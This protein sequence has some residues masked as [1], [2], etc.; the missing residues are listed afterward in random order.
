MKETKAENIKVPHITAYVYEDGKGNKDAII[1]HKE[2]DSLR[3]FSMPESA[4]A[5]DLGNA[6]NN[7][8]A[9]IEWDDDF[10]GLFLRQDVRKAF[11]EVMKDIFGDV[12]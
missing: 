8:M 7:R 12:K 2:S 1:L 4:T 6:V 5:E 9:G 10:T 3:C 11:S